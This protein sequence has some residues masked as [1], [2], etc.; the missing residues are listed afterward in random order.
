MTTSVPPASVATTVEA[1][2]EDV[3]E[4]GSIMTE[5]DRSDPFNDTINTCDTLNTT[6]DSEAGST[7]LQEGEE[8]LFADL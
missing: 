5:D 7:F 6:L 1:E 4:T 3:G 2:T 8:D